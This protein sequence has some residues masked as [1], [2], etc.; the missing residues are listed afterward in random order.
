MDQNY[1]T[2]LCISPSIWQ[3]I[4]LEKETEMVIAIFQMAFYFR[5]QNQKGRHDRFDFP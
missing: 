4:L 3:F 2:F 5:S 1:I